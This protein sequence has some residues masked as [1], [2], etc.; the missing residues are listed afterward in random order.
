MRRPKSLS[1]ACAIAPPAR[2]TLRAA[3]MSEHVACHHPLVVNAHAGDITMQKIDGQEF[4]GI[5]GG[6]QFKFSEAV[7]FQA[8]CRTQEEIDE[9]HE[10]LVRLAQ[11]EVR[12]VM[13]DLAGRAGATHGQQESEAGRGVMKAMLKMQKLDIRQLQRA[14]DEA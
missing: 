8:N 2:V 7:S 14:Y 3:A 4:T 9:L 13:A 10:K 12:P 6:P 5:N 11:G 1:C